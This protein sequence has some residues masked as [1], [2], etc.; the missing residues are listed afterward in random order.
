MTCSN[1]ADRWER[2]KEA[3]PVN[4]CLGTVAC[5]A[6]VRPQFGPVCSLQ[7][8][9]RKREAVW[10]AVVQ[11]SNLPCALVVSTQPGFSISI[12]FLRLI[13]LLASLPVV[14]SSSHSCMRLCMFMAPSIMRVSTQ[15][16]PH[17]LLALHSS[18][19]SSHLALASSSASLA[20]HSNL[21]CHC[22]SKLLSSD[23]NIIPYRGIVYRYGCN[24]RV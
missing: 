23:V 20:W 21:A 6:A 15:L 16:R 10:L 22:C 18:T 11:G 9:W 24:L 17:S 13:L 1:T 2:P 3:T 5:T 14:D 19:C 12:I 7:Q 8:R 4:K